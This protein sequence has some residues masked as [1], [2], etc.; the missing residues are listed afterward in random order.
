MKVDEPVQLKL[1]IPA[2]KGCQLGITYHFDYNYVVI[3]QNFFLVCPG[4]SNGL[5]VYA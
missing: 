1:V 2:Q 3:L 5:E 4:T